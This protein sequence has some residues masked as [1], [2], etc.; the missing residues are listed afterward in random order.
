MYHL[1]YKGKIVG[2]K[3]L[4][5]FKM[6]LY[7]QKSETIRLHKF[8]D[9]TQ[10]DWLFPN[11]YSKTFGLSVRGFEFPFPNLSGSLKTFIEPPQ[12]LINSVTGIAE[13]SSVPILATFFQGQKVIELSIKNHKNIP[14]KYYINESYF[15]CNKSD[16]IKG[17]FITALSKKISIYGSVS[18]YNKK[19]ESE[20]FKIV[21]P[22]EYLKFYVER[23]ASKN[24]LS[25]QLTNVSGNLPKL[26]DKKIHNF[27]LTRTGEKKKRQINEAI[28]TVII[29][30][31][32][33][34]EIAGGL[35]PVQIE[36][37]FDR[38]LN[39]LKSYKNVIYN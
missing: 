7:V 27:S 12:N 28:E 26:I 14:I 16:P 17:T 21:I 32:Q 37:E 35:N 8:D 9:S 6:V 5:Q 33:S 25:F 10:L 20:I 38:I 29:H 22:R 18:Y 30:A 24:F 34:F 2:D 23:D 13:T 4:S 1:A 19:T 11:Y 31:Q 36:I 3:R 15:L 39:M